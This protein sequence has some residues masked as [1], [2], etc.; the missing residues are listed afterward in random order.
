LNEKDEQLKE[1]NDRISE[2]E[3]KLLADDDVIVEINVIGEY[4]HNLKHNREFK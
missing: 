3:R 1:K 2:L 4:E